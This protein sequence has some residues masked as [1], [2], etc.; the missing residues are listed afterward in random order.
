MNGRLCIRCYTPSANGA[1]FKVYVC[2]PSG[3]WTQVVNTNLYPPNSPTTFDC[4][5][6]VNVHKVSIVDYHEY[7]GH[8]SYIYVD[9]V[10]IVK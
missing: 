8:P 3:V 10:C 7:S 2:T 9:A 6:V 1:N 4:G 5:Y